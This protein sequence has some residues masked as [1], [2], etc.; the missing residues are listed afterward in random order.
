[1]K[2]N[3]KGFGLIVAIFIIVILA[4][5]GIIGAAMFSMDTQVSL[6]TL[7]SMQAFYIAEAGIQDVMYRL[8]DDEDFRDDP[9]GDSPITGSLAIG[10]YSV[11][12]SKVDSTYTVTS[13]GTVGEVNRIITQ[14]IDVAEG[15]DPGF[16]DYVIFFGGGDGTNL[17]R[18]W[19]DSEIT[20][21]IFING[22]M[23]IGMNST[24]EGSVTATGDITLS[25]FGGITIT[26]GTF[27]NSDFP[28]EQPDFDTSYYEGEIQTAASES[29][30]D[31]NISGEIA[32]TTYVHGDVAINGN[33]T[34]SGAIV[35][36]GNIEIDAGKNIGDGITL[37][38]GD[39]LTANWRLFRGG[40][41][42]GSN[43][44]LYATNQVTLVGNTDI[45]QSGEGNGSVVLSD[46]DIFVG[47]SADIYGFVFGDEDVRLGV[48][49]D[50]EGNLAGSELVREGNWLFGSHCDIILNSELVDFASIQG[51]ESSG[52][53]TVTLG[54]W[55]EETS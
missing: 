19:R 2:Q 41:T 4:S 8:K 31:Q 17:S 26:E 45:G 7:R 39:T 1:M 29:A 50:I 20:G 27:P 11:A 42:I 34:G 30:G 16:L 38:S 10:S 22:D 43:C 13:T 12:V 35:A 37:I 21:D 33:L 3:K 25:P 49:A 32:G 40:V 36:T 53:A 52:E 44:L 23:Y 46:G 55:E 28:E 15:G 9:S 47:P 51:F 54:G 48:N 24:V 6:D 18:L 5:L 14:S